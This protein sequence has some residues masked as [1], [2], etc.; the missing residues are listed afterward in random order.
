MVFYKK[1]DSP[2]ACSYVISPSQLFSSAHSFAK[3]LCISLDSLCDPPC[4]D[5]ETC[6]EMTGKCVCD[7]TLREEEM[8]RRRRGNE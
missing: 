4:W 6:D 3:L 1:L 8:C 5:G 7:P 2:F